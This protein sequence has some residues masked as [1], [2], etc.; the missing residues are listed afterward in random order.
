MLLKAL[1]SQSSNI[2]C[3]DHLQSL[4][5]VVAFIPGFHVTHKKQGLKELLRWC[6][7]YCFRAVL[8]D[9]YKL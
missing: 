4:N 5:A 9:D 3:F 7:C 8:P 6:Y 2:F 1:H